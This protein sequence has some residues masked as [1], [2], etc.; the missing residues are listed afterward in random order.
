MTSGQ[1]ILISHLVGLACQNLGVAAL[2]ERL[3]TRDMDGQTLAWLAEEL[4][5]VAAIQPDPAG[6]FIYERHMARR[7]A[8]PDGMA[9]LADAYGTDGQ[10]WRAFLTSRAARVILP[11]R[12]ALA[13]VEE[14]FRPLTAEDG[15]RPW[16]SLADLSRRG[17]EGEL[18]GVSRWNVLGRTLLPALGSAYGRHVAAVAQL[19]SA[20]LTV[21]I[22][23]YGLARDAWP[24]SLDDLAPAFIKELPPDPLSG[25]PFGYKVLQTGWVLTAAADPALGLKVE[26]WEC[27]LTP[28]RAKP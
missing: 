17:R 1:D 18:A 5:R 26:P 10:V 20:R 23:R 25:K 8:S 13:E 2:R 11:D 19:D 6:G 21:A 27:R 15:R 24:T 7:F 3:L 16:Q 28:G 14:Y 4:D 22:R 12:L 9:A